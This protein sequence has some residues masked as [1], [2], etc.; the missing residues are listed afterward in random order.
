MILP[1]G[2]LILQINFIRKKNPLSGLLRSVVL[3]IIIP[4]L[5]EV[6][7]PVDTSSRMSAVLYPCA[8][9]PLVIGNHETDP[10]IAAPRLTTKLTERP[11]ILY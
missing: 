4:C 2:E 7:G 10:A 5:L 8:R 6:F 11:C 1:A 3:I 9:G